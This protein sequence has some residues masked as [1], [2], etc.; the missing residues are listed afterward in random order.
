MRR[1]HLGFP[2]RVGL[3]IACVGG[4]TPS[5]DPASLSRALR[6]R[7]GSPGYPPVDD[8]GTTKAREP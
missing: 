5:I 8:L 3:H 1:E 2:S 7:R 4:G 6:T